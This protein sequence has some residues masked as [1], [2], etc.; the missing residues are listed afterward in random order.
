[1]HGRVAN[2]ASAQRR[3]S[4]A[5][6]C[7]VAAAGLPPGSRAPRSI[8]T[9][10]RR[11]P[12]LR[13]SLRR[14]RRPDGRL[15]LGPAFAVTGLQ[16]S[17]GPWTGGTRDDHHG[18]RLLLERPVLDRRDP[19]ALERRLRQRSHAG[20]R[21]HAPRHARAPPTSPSRTSAPAQQATLPAGFIYDAFS[22][23]PG[24]G[25][26]TGGTR[27]A[28]EGKRHHVD[29]RVRRSPSA[30]SPCTDVTFT[31]ATDLRASRPPTDPARRRHS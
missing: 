9:R 24:T 3:R 8:P 20:R 5:L 11:G 12:P 29:G 25:A 1:M 30:A 23:T 28:L 10:R 19:L 31:D 22:V 4:A 27:I 14:R 13:R 21:H 18:P 7:V 6:A 15:D 26:T 16:P 2:V 17:H